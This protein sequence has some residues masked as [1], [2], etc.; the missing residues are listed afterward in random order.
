MTETEVLINP[1]RL[2]S[3]IQ[4]FTPSSLVSHAL[5]RILV[6]NFLNDLLLKLE[7]HFSVWMGYGGSEYTFHASQ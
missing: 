4:M 1:D 6:Y 2:L 7:M 3:D 5:Y